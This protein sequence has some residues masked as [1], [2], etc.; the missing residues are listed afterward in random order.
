MDIVVHRNMKTDGSLKLREVTKGSGDLCGG[1]FVDEA[2]LAHLRLTIPTFEHYAATEPAELLRGLMAKWE[3]VKR[4]F[5]GTDDVVLDLPPKLA[6]AL[7]KARAEASG[8]DEDDDDTFGTRTSAPL[9]LRD[10]ADNNNVRRCG[11]TVLF[12]RPTNAAAC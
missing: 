2:F 8:Y 7:D 6:R 9:V 4:S 11:G 1:T 12:C 3:L 10:G 5:D